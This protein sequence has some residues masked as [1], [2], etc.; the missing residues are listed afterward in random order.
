MSAKRASRAKLVAAPAKDVTLRKAPA[1][2]RAKAS[3]ERIFEATKKL[4]DSRGLDQ[5]NTNHIVAESGLSTGA[6]Y[7]F[8]PNKEAILFAMVESWLAKLQQ[9]YCDALRDVAQFATPFEWIEFILLRNEECY[10]NEPVIAR[11]YNALTIL[12][13]LRRLDAEHDERAG[14]YMVDAQLAFSPDVSREQA[15]VNATTM[16]LMIHNILANTVS[17]DA[18]FSSR[19]RAELRYCLNALIAKYQN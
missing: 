2:Q 14:N 9:G 6:I 15:K 11:Y 17:Q 1:Q 18:V 13:D 3:I 4:L 7:N 12:P 19:M 5:I 8:F 16:I 10:D